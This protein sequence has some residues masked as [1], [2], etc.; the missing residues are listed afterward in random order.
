LTTLERKIEA[1]F[2]K[3]KVSLGRPVHQFVAELDI[4]LRNLHDIPP[5]RQHQQQKAALT[6]LYSNLITT[7]Q[8]SHTKKMFF[9]EPKKVPPPRTRGKIF[10]FR[11][12]EVSYQITSSPSRNDKI[13]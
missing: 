8:S 12:K 9:T 11:T 6:N 4:M 5:I 2:R 13:I 1:R 7:I 3:K 10:F